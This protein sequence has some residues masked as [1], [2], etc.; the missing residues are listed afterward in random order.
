MHGSPLVVF[1]LVIL[2]RSIHDHFS[3]FFQMRASIKNLFTADCAW[4]VTNA[5]FITLCIDLNIGKW[6]LTERVLNCLR[7]ETMKINC[8]NRTLIVF[9]GNASGV[10]WLVHLNMQSVCRFKLQVELCDRHISNVS[11]YHE[12]ELLYLLNIIVVKSVYS[13]DD[14]TKNNLLFWFV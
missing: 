2:T 9:N 5:L 11:N 3:H 10:K 7:H 8:I 13:C 12:N 4:I 6:N 1:F 14:L